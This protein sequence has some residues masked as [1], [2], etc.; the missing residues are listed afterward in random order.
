M[1]ALT[2]RTDRQASQPRRQVTGHFW[3]GRYKAQLLLDE[4]AVLACAIY[5]DLNPIRAAMAESLEESDFT[6]AKARIDDLKD[7]NSE[8][9]CFRC[10]FDRKTKFPT[11]NP[12]KVGQRQTGANA[13]MGKEQRQNQ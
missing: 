6:G 12:N 3:E 13:A 5:V 9:H 11:H 2:P 8:A 1:D 10:G 7:S 4:A